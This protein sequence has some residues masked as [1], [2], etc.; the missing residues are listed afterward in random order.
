MSLLKCYYLN[1]YIPYHNVA[2]LRKNKQGHLLLIGQ[3]VQSKTKHQVDIIDILQEAKL[4]VFHALSKRN[5]KNQPF[6]PGLKEQIPPMKRKQKLLYQKSFF[7]KT[8]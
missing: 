8:K 2:V 4:N 3:S 7:N 6:Q 1:Y 5:K